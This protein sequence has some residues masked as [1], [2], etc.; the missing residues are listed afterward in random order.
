MKSRI[1]I[2]TTDPSDW[3]Q[4]LKSPD[5]HWK[6]DYSAHTLA[7]RWHEADG[8]PNEIEAL[9]IQSD[10]PALKKTVPILI[11]PERI[12]PIGGRGG[13]CRNDVFVLAK[14]G[15]KAL[16]SIT[17]E[18]KVDESFGDPLGYWKS[19]GNQQNRRS[20]LDFLLK[21]LGLGA[22]PPDT[23]FYQLIQRTAAA[24]VEAELFNANYAVM[25]VH[26]F[27]AGQS[28]FSAFQEFARL[29]K[30]DVAV[31]QLVEIAQ[32]N[33]IRLFVGW[34]QGSKPLLIHS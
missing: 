20:R 29:F 10:L 4:F 11:I 1:Y 12:T 2:P 19:I 27:S 31:G 13:S 18:G 14:A 28:H 25:I 8:F 16:V 15:D 23:I 5:K 17:F 30:K 34:A 33:E 21:K 6:I 9:F 32:I 3:K 26:S 7:H 22:D 24:I